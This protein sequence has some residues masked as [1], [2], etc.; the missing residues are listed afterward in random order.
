LVNDQTRS[1]GASHST[2][3]AVIARR[4]QFCFGAADSEVPD[5]LDEEYPDEDPPLEEPELPE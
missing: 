3:R 4:G 5:D 1:V 2:R